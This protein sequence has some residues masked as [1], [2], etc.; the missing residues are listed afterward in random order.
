[1]MIRPK[2]RKSLWILALA[3]LSGGSLFSDLSAGP[4]DEPFPEV[5]KLTA[6][7]ADHGDGLGSA[8]ALE[9]DIAV[10]GAKFKDTAAG[11]QAGAAY[12]YVR[13]PAGWSEV[14][15]LTAS[16]GAAD[17]EFGRATAINGDTVVV[18]SPQLFAGF[19]AA[20]VYSRGEGGPDAWVETARLAASDRGS[21]DRFGY[22]VAIDG[23]TIAVGSPQ[24]FSAN[25]AVYVFTR[26]GGGW[27]QRARLS[28]PS[29]AV[30]GDQL[31]LSVAISGD[32][33]VAGAPG[34]G[35][36]G[37][38]F[39]YQGASDNWQQVAELDVAGGSFGADFGGSVAIDGDTIVVGA[40][41]DDP[42]CC[43]EGSAVVFE[44]HRGGPDAWGMVA[45]LTASDAEA[46]DRLGYSVDISGDL[47]ILG[48]PETYNGG[49][50]SAY[51]F[52]RDR[53]GRDQ[54]G[55]IARLAA[56][57]IAI[58]DLFGWAVAVD[59]QTALAGSF[60]HDTEFLQ[61]GAAYL[62]QACGPDPAI[63]CL[64]DGRFRVEA[65][66]TDF[67][68]NTGHGTAVAARSMDSGMLWFFHPD[69][70]EVLV[71]V[72]DGCS[73]NQ[74]FWVFAAATTDVAYTLE[75]TD[76]AT[77]LVRSYTNPLGVASPAITDTEAFA[78]CPGAAR[79]EVPAVGPT[80]SRASSR[81]AHSVTPEIQSAN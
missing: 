75:V 73:I 10:V 36:N 58:S 41:D 35:V 39:V 15:R 14:A 28:E 45:R 26:E 31:G 66:W 42:V 3:F 67:A 57:D 8:V 6:S 32:T 49:R 80:T 20:Y 60:G 64:H 56:S 78:I 69:N 9:G 4:L 13:S 24:P 81:R 50:G 76:T 16:D 54:W 52:G 43:S 33:L 12:V 37:V 34:Y 44:R 61:A 18:G 29:E 22:S 27:S 47:T 40:S 19:G 63:L 59:G 25:G 65:E 79:V 70:W 51:L 17:H 71:K 72:L 30:F 62:Y 11:H 53:G 1:M 74:R 7:D 2:R 23:N 5:A 46:G 38:A 55:E 48:A 77:G 68:G 21:E